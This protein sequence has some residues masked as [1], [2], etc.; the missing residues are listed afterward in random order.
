[1]MKDV[2]VGSNPTGRAIY[3]STA[4][5]F[6]VLFFLFVSFVHWTCTCI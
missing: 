3:E 4:I 1:M 5:K 2:V 6:A